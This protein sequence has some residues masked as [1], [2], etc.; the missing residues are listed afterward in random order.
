V[1][2]CEL[3]GNTTNQP[4]R[5]PSDGTLGLCGLQLSGAVAITPV[6]RRDLT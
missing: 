6:T 5:Q 1:R 4:V 3:T 2:Y